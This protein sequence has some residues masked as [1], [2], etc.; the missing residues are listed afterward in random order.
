MYTSMSAFSHPFSI[1]FFPSRHICP[2]GSD[3]LLCSAQSQEHPLHTSR[4]PVE[5][6]LLGPLQ[7]YCRKHRPN[8]GQRNYI[9]FYICLASEASLPSPRI[10][11]WHDFSI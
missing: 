4:Q 1:T 5:R 8:T 3:R 10:Y 2:L 7:Y 9:R 11:E 6:G